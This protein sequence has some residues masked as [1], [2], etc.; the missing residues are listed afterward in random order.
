MSEDELGKERV[1]VESGEILIYGHVHQPGIDYQLA[2][3][4][5][6]T[7]H[8][9]GGPRSSFLIIDNGKITL[10]FWPPQQD[11]EW[12]IDDRFNQLKCVQ[13]KCERFV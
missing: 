6:W 10:R 2:N 3:T 8:E 9:T 7:E 12:V 11:N 4:G 13:N 1:Y 5:S